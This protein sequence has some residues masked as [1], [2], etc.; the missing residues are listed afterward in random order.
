MRYLSIFIIANAC[1]I[2]DPTSPG[3]ASAAGFDCEK[4]HTNVEKLICADPDLS[5]LDAELAKDFYA[6][7]E[8]TWGMNA[9]TGQAFFPFGEDQ[10]HW[11][12]TVRDKCRSTNCLKAA[13][14]ARLAKV[15]KDWRDILREQ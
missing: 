1:L 15:R 12:M 8:E 13:Y 4:A 9:E 7:R 2:L 10:E 14:E 11:R 3:S 6:I 5:W